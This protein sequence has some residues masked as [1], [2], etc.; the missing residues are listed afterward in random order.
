MT[1]KILLAMKDSDY[2]GFLS[3][4]LS[5]R[6]A[7]TFEVSTFSNLEQLAEMEGRQ[8][9]DIALLDD[10][11]ADAAPASIARLPLLLWDGDSDF[12]PSRDGMGQIR[13]YQRISAISA[14]L[15][16]LFAEV[17][18]GGKDFD[19]KSGRITVVWSPAGGCGKTTVALAYAAWLVS[20]GR[21]TTYLDLEPFSSTDVFFAQHGR[22]LSAVFEKMESNITLLLKGI[23]QTDI[24][25]GIGYFS[26]PE[27]Y[28][29]ISI[30]SAEDA[31]LVANACA[32]NAN[33]VVIDLG[34]GYD[35]KTHALLEL[36]DSVLLV[37]DGSRVS[38]AKLEQFRIQHSEYEQISEKTVMVF[39]KGARSGPDDGTGSVSLPLVQ[40]ADPVVIFKNLSA[41]YF[42]SADR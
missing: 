6:Y 14:Q 24:P 36:A 31:V 7:R 16:E 20:Q 27:N 34:S 21:K 11:A 15:L 38:T 25:T 18:H 8:K 23:I 33:E 3:R 26:R 4:V 5:D 12:S 40:S 17:H 9:Y 32:G 19:E 39:N 28:D 30:L 42:H 37:T 2:M 41:G 29:D 1:I 10:A 22:S 13:K 35:Q